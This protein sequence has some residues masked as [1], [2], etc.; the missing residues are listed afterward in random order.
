MVTEPQAALAIRLLALDVDGVL[1]DGRV[2]YASDGSE[3][4]SFNIKD[5]LGIKLLQRCGIRVAIITGRRSDMVA[6]RATELGIADLYEGREDKLSALQEL[7]EHLGLTLSECAYMGDDLPD[8]GAICAAGIGMTVSDAVPE[9]R[10]AA[11]WC[12][13]A[14]GGAGA[15]REAAEWLLQARGQWDDLLTEFR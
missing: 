6:R 15:V 4:K 3:L 13:R 2:T 11:D 10:A 9:V 1:S 7:G 12:S 14:P 5:G 8:L